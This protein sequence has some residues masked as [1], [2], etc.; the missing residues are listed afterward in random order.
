MVAWA[1]WWALVAFPKKLIWRAVG[2]AHAY[3][4]SPAHLSL[5]DHHVMARSVMEVM[6]QAHVDTHHCKV[7]QTGFFQTQ[8]RTNYP[9]LGL[10]R[11]C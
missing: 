8:C 7:Q 3:A 10:K 4:P 6:E 1:V 2:T 11:V 9:Y 5:D